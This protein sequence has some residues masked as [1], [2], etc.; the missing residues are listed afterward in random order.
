[1]SDRRARQ[2][3]RRHV[4]DYMDIDEEPDDLQGLPPPITINTHAYQCPHCD[5]VLMEGES[6]TMCCSGGKAALPGDIIPNPSPE[7]VDLFNIPS[8]RSRSRR[9]NT[10][11]ALVTVGVHVGGSW[12][13]ADVH[14]ATLSIHG[15]LYHAILPRDTINSPLTWVI[16]DTEERVEVGQHMHKLNVGYINI[17]RE[18]S[19][20]PVLTI[21]QP[22][23]LLT[24]PVTFMV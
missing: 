12:Q 3:I 13:N 5:V 19:H 23:Y 21:T 16:Y 4:R 2:Y 17:L 18:V 20:T 10:H 8:F 22:S 14:P 9:Y 7:I 6:R 11:F 15:S 24:T 1:M